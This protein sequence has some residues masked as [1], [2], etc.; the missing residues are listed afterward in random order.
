MLKKFKQKILWPF[1]TLK[2]MYWKRQVTK[3]I[4]ILEM[5]DKMM[6]KAGYTRPQRRRLWR[7]FIK[8]HSTRVKVYQTLKASLPKRRGK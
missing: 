6:I 4:K 2:K 7:D 5:F 1:S 8:I 3:A